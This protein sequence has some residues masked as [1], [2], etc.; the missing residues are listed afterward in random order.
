[1]PQ[2]ISLTALKMACKKLGLPRWPYLRTGPAEAE[3]KKKGKGKDEG[4]WATMSLELG[5][6]MEDA[7][8]HC[9]KEE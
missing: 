6:L 7:M 1:M 2:G 9:C 4:R 8:R 5:E 3:E